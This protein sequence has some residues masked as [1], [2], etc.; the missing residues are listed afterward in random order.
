MSSLCSCKRSSS[1]S[2]ALA[3]EHQLVASQDLI[4]V[5]NSLVVNS[6]SLHV[7]RARLKFLSR[8]V[9]TSAVSVDFKFREHFDEAFGLRRIELDLFHDEDITGI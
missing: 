2:K 8:S 5:E 7:A 1:F 4:G 3:R 6:T 9:T